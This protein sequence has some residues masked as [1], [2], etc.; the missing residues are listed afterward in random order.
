[1]LRFFNNRIGKKENELR[2][3][4]IT[5]T[6]SGS[7]T[8]TGVGVNAAGCDSTATLD[9]TVQTPGCT[10]PA[11][12]EFNSDAILDDGSCITL[13]SSLYDIQSDSLNSMNLNMETIQSQFDSLTTTSLGL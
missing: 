7:Y 4:I 8:W 3:P 6:T 1:M 10:D 5:K 13:F 9:L 11:Y 2:N 12:Q